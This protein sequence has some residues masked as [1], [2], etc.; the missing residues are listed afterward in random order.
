MKK[1][2]K[3]ILLLF[4]I[5][6]FAQAPP[7]EWQK[8][9]GAAN[10]DSSREICQTNDLGYIIVGGTNSNTGNY[11]SNHGGFDCL[12]IKTDAQ[13]TI[14]WQKLFGGS[15]ND[16]GNSIKQTS[17]GGYIIAGRSES[18]NGDLTLNR[19]FEDY[20]VLKLNS[21]GTIEWQ[22]TYGGNQPDAAYSI[23]QTSDNGYVVMGR[24]SSQNGD[25]AVNSIQGEWIIKLNSTGVIQWQRSLTSNIGVNSEKIRQ[26][27]DNSFIL[28]YTASSPTPVVVG[29]VTTYYSDSF[30]V[31]LDQ[32]GVVQFQKNYGGSYQETFQDV[33]QTNDLGYIVISNSKSNNLDVSGHHG[34]PTDTSNNGNDDLWVTKV[35][36]TGIIQWQKS[37]GGNYNDDAASIKQTT[38]GSYII[39]GSTNSTNGDVSGLHGSSDYWLVKLN[40][41]GTILWQKCYGGTNFD[42]A[43]FITVNADNTYILSG[44]SYSTDGDI[45]Q[46]FGGSDIWIVKLGQELSVDDFQ[47][48]K[49]SLYP[50][51]TSNK[52]T[53][54]VNNED[55][56]DKI[57]VTDLTGKIILVQTDNTNQ[58]NTESLATGTYFIQ[59]F[60]GENKFQSTFIKE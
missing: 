23:L 48:N 25:H 40:S 38:D 9:F 55:A 28:G 17:D 37:L 51:P 15:E 3:L 10:N 16:F 36:A 2:K 41:S 44:L 22:K 20:W 43:N 35:N 60:S 50:N 14:Q 4:T 56:I 33:L 45:T 7:I 29:S 21:S 42:I 8:S 32:L 19:G 12:V 6:C 13:G 53:I 58:I 31:K 1:M 26:T 59:A 18:N 52:L 34:T 24:S 27:S 47:Q 30:I 57:I 39:F 46:N 11:S 54:Q 49:I 5:N